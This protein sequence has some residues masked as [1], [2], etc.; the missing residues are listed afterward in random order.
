M[1]S[2][3]GKAGFFFKIL[4]VDHKILL[5]F[6]LCKT[7]VFIK[8]MSPGSFYIT[9]QTDLIIPFSLAQCFTLRPYPH[10]GNSS[11]KRKI[12]VYLFIYKSEVQVGNK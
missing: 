7:K 12:R 9:M 4:Y 6:E 3:K 10:S 5:L 2:F 8:Q 1:L 11:Q